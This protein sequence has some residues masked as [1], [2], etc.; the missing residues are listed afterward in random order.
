MDILGE[1]GHYSAYHT[2][3]VVVDIIY[4]TK[5]IHYLSECTSRRQQKQT[6]N[7]VDLY[8]IDLTLGLI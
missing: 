4:L 3:A 1:R 2:R 7:A 8:I 5:I 6:K